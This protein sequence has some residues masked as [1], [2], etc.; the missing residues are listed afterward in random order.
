MPGKTK[1]KTKPI[2][3]PLKG[4]KSEGLNKC[5]GGNFFESCYVCIINFINFLTDF[6]SDANFIVLLIQVRGVL[7]IV[8]VEGGKAPLYV[9]RF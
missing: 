9:E 1:F 8:K 2:F 7:I 4:I 6:P 3:G 5:V